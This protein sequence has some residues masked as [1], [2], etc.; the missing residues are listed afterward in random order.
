MSQSLKRFLWVALLASG[1]QASWA[2]SL[3]GPVG[4]GDDTWQVTAIGY[5]PLGVG[6][7]PPFLIDGLLTGPKNLGE[8][9]RRNTPFLYYTCDANFLDY[10]GSNGVVAVDQAFVILNNAFTNNPTG[11][12]NGLDG[13]SSGLSEFS[14]D[15]MSANYQAQALGLLDMKSVTLALMTEQLGLA[16]SVRYTWALHDRFQPTGTTCPNSTT[17]TVIMRN[18]DITASPL[19]Q[20]QYSPYVNAVLYSYYIYED[21]AGAGVSPPDA[22]AIEV[23]VDPLANNPPVAS[24]VDGLLLGSFYTGLT[25]DDMAGLRYLLSSNNVNTEPGDANSLQLFTNTAPDV[26]LTN[27]PLSQ[28][29]SASQF[30]SPAQLQALFPG[31]VIASSSN[32]LQVV[33]ATNLTAFFT[34]TPAITNLESEQLFSNLDLG[35]FLLQAQTDSPP[36]L[37]ALY[38]T[39]NILN[40]SNYFIAV[41]VPNIVSYFT[42]LISSPAT[43]PPTF[44]VKTNGYSSNI[45]ERYTYVFGNI[46]TNF[47]SPSNKVTI[48]NITFTNLIG[49]PAGSQTILT[50]NSSNVTIKSPSGDFFIIPT[51]W[52]GFTTLY[53]VLVQKTLSTSNVITSA[54]VNNSTTVFQGM[55]TLLTYY[56]NRVLVIEPDICLPSLVFG[57]NV[58]T[59]V[60]TVFQTTFANILTNFSS[61]SI[62][63]IL[64]TNIGPCPGGVPTPFCT[65][66][67]FTTILTNTPTGQFFILPTN[68][69]GFSIV[70]TVQANFVALTNTTLI[71][72]NG[73]QLFSQS[74]VT[75]FTNAILLIQPEVCSSAS[76]GP[77]LRRGIQKIQF[78]RA[79][80][81]SLLGQF[82]QPVT[83]DY[84]VMVISNSQPGIQNFQRVITQ[85]DILFTATDFAPGPAAGPADFPVPSS[86][87]IS[88]SADPAS[89]YPG[90]AGPGLI[91][92]PT[93]ITYDKVGPLF[94]NIGTSFLS[95][96]NFDAEAFIWASFDG[97]TNDPVVY[98]NGTS[99]QNLENE[100]LV[101]ISPASLPDGTNNMAYPPTTFTASGGSFSQ[102]F[103]W[104]ATGLPMGLSIG[105]NPD[106]TGTLSGTPT[107]SGTFDFVIQ[108]TDSLGRSVQWNYSITIN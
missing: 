10:F 36:V 61:N 16:D 76:S 85:P 39:L 40:S 3:L 96:N 97:S 68:F 25:R 19:N 60:V 106:S 4:T 29:L 35:L 26:L 28:L 6:A 24:E 51:N 46:V 1:L 44:V 80:F 7:A 91:N 104:S 99:I 58:T 12:T 102:P 78:A 54:A 21:C 107:Q 82:F 65:N 59:N 95:G 50:T 62:V 9:Y 5:N 98:P 84:S 13:Y 67:T 63:S 20:V 48:Q 27:L 94:E 55:Q 101:Q 11:M 93:T 66:I 72:T 87:S 92:T 70:S 2:Y 45:V 52:C 43:A 31:L 37:Q 32:F 23:P 38:P 69:C 71:I 108:L 53:T 33:V 8:E 34:N 86:R 79:N 30:L 73:D 81:D 56:T 42:N 77:I 41:G 49:A 89:A 75:Y 74:I 15:T 18:F 83:N 105:T 57:T 22:D 103:T 90:Q 100:V 17:Y 14:L 47:Y 64:T 88:F